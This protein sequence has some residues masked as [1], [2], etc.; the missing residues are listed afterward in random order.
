MR[1]MSIVKTF[2]L[3]TAFMMLVGLGPAQ[4][5]LFSDNFDSG[6]SSLWGN[7]TG[8]WYADGGVYN[9]TTPGN[10]PYTYSSIP[11]EM[12]DFVIEVDMNNAGDGGI[13]LR[14]TYYG[15]NDMSGVLLVVGGNY[16]G[17]DGMYFHYCNHGVG[18]SDSLI[19]NLFTPGDNLHVKVV[20]SGNS[21]EAFLYKDGELIGNTSYT[22]PDFFSGQVALYDAGPFYT[23][24]DLKFDNVSLEGSPVPL[25]ST[26]LLLG[27]G[28]LGLA[29]FG[30]RFRRS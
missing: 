20:V 21:Y 13:W 26:L 19:D 14:S 25:P 30:R 22:T 16:T 17:F 4:A 23:E 24:Q 6:A 29:G 15:E 10:S 18:D 11:Y 12:R 2:I 9:A 5:T 28:I 8:G 7:E 1:K 3:A 27:T